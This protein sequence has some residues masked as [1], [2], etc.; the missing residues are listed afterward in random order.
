MLQLNG[1]QA[2]VEVDGVE[3]KQYDVETLAD[4]KTATSW[5]ASEVDKVRGVQRVHPGYLGS[6]CR[7]FDLPEIFYTLER[8]ISISRINSGE[9]PNRW[10][11]M[12]GEI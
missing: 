2:W 4:E 7:S 11:R 3:L 8:Y 10:Y 9:S 1:F 5:I 6:S 12:W